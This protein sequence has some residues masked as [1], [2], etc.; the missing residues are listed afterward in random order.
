MELLAGAVAVIE[1]DNVL[2]AI[3]KLGPVA[4]DFDLVDKEFLTVFFSA[5]PGYLIDAGEGLL[6]AVFS[7]RF[8]EFKG[9]DVDFF[10]FAETH[11][12]GLLGHGVG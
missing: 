3:S 11:G 9:A 4:L 7:T 8:L 2:G 5:A 12:L 6:V 1:I 10:A